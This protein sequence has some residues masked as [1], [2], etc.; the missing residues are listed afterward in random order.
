VFGGNH[1][2][3]SQSKDLTTQAKD[4]T[5]Q[6][7]PI[8]TVDFCEMVAHPARYFDRTIRINAI[9]EIGDEG[10]N[11]NNVRCVR[12]HD[13][14]IGAGAERI[15]D[16]QVEFLNQSHKAI[17]S[18]KFGMQPSVTVIGILRNQSLRAFAWYRYRFD[19]IR[20][21]Y[22]RQEVSET[23]ANFDGSLRAGQTYRAMVRGDENFGLN[24][25]FFPLRIP[26]QQAVRLEWTNLQAFRAL[27]NLRSV[28]QK[29]IIFRVTNDD[30]S[31]MGPRRWDRTLQ[32]Q[33][34]MVE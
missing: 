21:E 19:I 15:N 23:I 7:P 1:I 9:L 26:A 14:S 13:D 2:A 20:F 29:Q 27:H 17:M 4:L 31:Q 33:I 22:I 10:S 28:D 3:A 25:A 5:R 24:F 16:R 18:G 6:D 12:S 34:L 30:I 8:P 32:L 11:V